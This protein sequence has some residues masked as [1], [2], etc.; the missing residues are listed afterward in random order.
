MFFGDWLRWREMLSPNKPALIDAINDNQPITFR[1]WNG[2]A[3]VEIL[4]R[5]SWLAGT[6]CA[7]EE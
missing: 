5:C 1:Q 4:N 6:V 2:Q 3:C 7:Y